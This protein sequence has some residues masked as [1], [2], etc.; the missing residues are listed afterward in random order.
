LIRTA[1]VAVSNRQKNSQSLP[2]IYD[3]IIIGLGAM[4]SSAA[5]QLAKKGVKVLG[6][7]RFSPPHKFGSTHG[8][9]RITRQAIGEGAEYVPLALRSY[10]IF[11]EIEAETNADLLTITGGLILSKSSG[12]ALHGN[13]DFIET[14]VA[15]AKKFGIK[16]RV[17]AADEIAK[18]FP[19]FKSDGNERGYFEDESGFLR[20]ENCVETQLDSAEKYG[21]KINRNEQVAEIKHFQT[22]VEVVTD[23]ETCRAEK[24]I[25]SVGA[26]IKN[27][28]E[29]PSRDLFKI[30]RQTFY[31]FDVADN[32]EKFKLG[33]F[34]TFI[35]EFGR[36]ENDFV[37]GFPAIDG[38]F[39]GLKIA[40]ETYFSTTNPDNVNREVTPK[41]IARIFEKYVENRIIGVSKKCLRTATCLY[42][43]T[44]NA[45]FIIDKLPGN[46]RII[47]ASPCSGH[48]FKHSAAIGEILAKLAINEKSS[49]DISPFLFNNR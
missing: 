6:I 25:L 26:W 37:Y 24:I 9:T 27:F 36:S 42:T 30:Y 47:V 22:H 49:I 10:E 35:W 2:M 15:T 13:A 8:E 4:G 23:K 38:Q 17:L 18:E 14:T 11:R 39:G 1:D 33:N 45:R 5:Y 41:E 19:Q 21:A 29:Q 28:V 43:V 46:E 3:V 7:D 31:W 34:P 48:G 16:H 32:F 20:P 12:N 44:P 40:T